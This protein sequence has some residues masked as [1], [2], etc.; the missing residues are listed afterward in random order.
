MKKIYFSLLLIL[1]L[2]PAA[3]RAN[4]YVDGIGMYGSMGDADTLLG[5]GA[6]IG[7]DVLPNTNVYFKFM[8]GT[9]SDVNS[10]NETTAEYE[11]K[12]FS[13][14]VEYKY[15]VLKRLPLY[16][17]NSIG[18]GM[19]DVRIDKSFTATGLELQENGV[20]TAFW[21]GARYDLTQHIGFFALAG[22]Q[23]V[24][25]FNGELDGASVGGFQL[26]AG[27]TFTVWGLNASLYD[28]Y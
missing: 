22:Y 12:I 7:Y 27:V 16:W 2:I 20:Y 10:A 23:K 28:G 25:G 1:L 13:G 21:T 4:I 6:G 19:A 11:S 26:S 5:Y 15:Q 18:I 14:V 8:M 17:S 24:L 9:S 3:A